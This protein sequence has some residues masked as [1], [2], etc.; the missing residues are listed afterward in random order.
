MTL[1]LHLPVIEPPPEYQEA[2]YSIRSRSDGTSTLLLFHKTQPTLW[3][4]EEQHQWC[5]LKGHISEL[6]K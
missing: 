1:A 6:D 3:Y 2:S 5:V 4:C